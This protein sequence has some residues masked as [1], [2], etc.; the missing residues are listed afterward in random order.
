MGSQKKEDAKPRRS[1]TK[2]REERRSEKQERD[3]LICYRYAQC[4]NA[5][6]VGKEHGVNHMYV[7][8]AW[9]RLT[10][11]E[12]DALLNVREQIDEE[13][14]RK[15]IKAEQIAG[16]EFVANVV[17]ARELIGKELI[18]RCTGKDIRII[19]DKDFTSLTR[20]VA[21]ITSSGEED[22]NDDSPQSSTFSAYRQA[23]QGK[24]NDTNK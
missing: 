17:R 8:R 13:L 6:L 1:A 11:D 15:L 20:L 3:K 12:R 10:D 23:I 16:D 24:I 19:S 21:S 22:K 2:L 14:N 4:R 18:R 7:L 5:S 9:E